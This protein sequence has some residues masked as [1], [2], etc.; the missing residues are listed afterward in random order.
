MCKRL[1]NLKFFLCTLIMLFLF[2]CAPQIITNIYQS[3]PTLAY[4]KDVAVYD[5]TQEIPENAQ[6]LGVVK[7]TD[8]GFTSKCNYD[9]MLYKVVIEARKVGGNLVKIMEHKK[10]DFWSSCHR[11]TAVIYK[12]D[13]NVKRVPD[14]DEL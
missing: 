4:W 14:D 1:Y 6:E 10:P 5:M 13:D 8:S 9:Y 11:I 7:A 2:S 3:Y 12:T